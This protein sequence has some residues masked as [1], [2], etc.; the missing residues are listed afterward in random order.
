MIHSLFPGI[1]KLVQHFSEAAAFKAL[2][3]R[4]R[5]ANGHNVVSAVCPQNSWMYEDVAEKKV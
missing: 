2:V 3:M 5:S 4:S 1:F